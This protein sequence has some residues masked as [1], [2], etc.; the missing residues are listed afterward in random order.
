[1]NKR[2]PTQASFLEGDYGAKVLG[3]KFRPGDIVRQ[4]WPWIGHYQVVYP[5]FHVISWAL[6]DAGHRYLCY[7]VPYGSCTNEITWIPEKYL[8]PLGFSFEVKSHKFLTD[9]GII[10]RYYRQHCGDPWE[11]GWPAEYMAGIHRTLKVPCGAGSPYHE[12]G[13]PW[14]DQAPF[15]WER[16]LVEFLD[17]LPVKW[18]ECTRDNWYEKFPEDK[19]GG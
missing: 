9:S 14:P 1:L 7:A 10:M 3:A 4:N 15:A 5:Y 13:C 12:T 16:E 17:S 2:D 6:D 8:V 18:Y 11:E 19:K